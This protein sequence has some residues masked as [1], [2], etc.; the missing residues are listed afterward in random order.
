M[1]A[2]QTTNTED[3]ALN[4]ADNI[5]ET[6]QKG[7]VWM[8]LMVA[9]SLLFS[10]LTVWLYVGRNMVA[11]ITRLDASMR[12]IANGNLDEPVLVKGGDEIGTMARSLVS[13]QIGRAHV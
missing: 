6:I 9:M 8:V 2:V 12:A 7:R 11:R 13:F 1:I 3:A 10:I 5:R 4:S